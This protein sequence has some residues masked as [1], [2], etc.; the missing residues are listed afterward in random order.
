MGQ[1]KTSIPAK[2]FRPPRLEVEDQTAGAEAGKGER[3]PWS[4]HLG[5]KCPVLP[6]PKPKGKWGFTRSRA[7]KKGG[8]MRVKDVPPEAVL[9]TDRQDREALLE[10]VGLP[11]C[12]LR[13]YPCLFA[14]V[15]EGEI[16]RVWGVPYA[17]PW[18]EAPAEELYRLRAMLSAPQKT[19]AKAREKRL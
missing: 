4:P 3:R 9:L 19:K 2:P 11:E 7:V 8:R 15:G 12:Y 5:L 6:A 1:D 10:S 17:V 13:D 16:L 14:L 18:L